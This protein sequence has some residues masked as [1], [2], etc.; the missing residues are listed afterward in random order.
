LSAKAGHRNPKSNRGLQVGDNR[1][2]KQEESKLKDTIICSPQ[3]AV[4]SLVNNMIA[5][6]WR[7]TK[8]VGDDH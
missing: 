7:P 2:Q 8:N 1:F 3:R 6:R 4:K 5:G